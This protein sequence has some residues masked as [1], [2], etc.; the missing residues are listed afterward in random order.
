MAMKW[1][2]VGDK[3]AKR[4]VEDFA[5]TMRMNGHGATVDCDETA[6]TATAKEELAVS[7]FDQIVRSDALII[8]AAASKKVSAPSLKKQTIL[9]I[10]LALNKRIVLIG[11]RE[12]PFHYLAMVQVYRNIPDFLDQLTSEE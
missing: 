10:A 5:N 4:K 11:E 9:G 6:G 12:Q 1:H 8:F 3:G 7:A 2:I